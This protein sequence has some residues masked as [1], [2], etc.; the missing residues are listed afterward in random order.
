M[1]IFILFTLCILSLSAGAEVY[2]W[3]DSSGKVGY[4]NVPPGSDVHYKEFSSK[5]KAP[6]SALKSNT[7]EK[8][9]TG[10]KDTKSL[11]D[12]EK[13]KKI[14]AQNCARSRES[15][16]MLQSGVRVVRHNDKGE[17]EVLDDKMRKD[18]IINA[19]KSIEDWCTDLKK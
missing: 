17:R 13:D 18:E 3:Q 15:L 19:Q 16:Q 1:R 11:E 4:G 5:N 2:K 8:P 12:E 9:A 7:V 10:E 14:A 6:D